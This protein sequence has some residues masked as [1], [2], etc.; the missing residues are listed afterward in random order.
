MGIKFLKIG[1]VY[2]VL[3]IFLGIIMGAT[4]NFEFSSVHAHLSLLG[5]VSMGL[6]G[7]IYHFYPI[8]GETKLAKVHFWLHN[9]G[10]PLLTGG[11]FIVLSSGESLTFLPIIGSNILGA[12]VILFAINLFKHVKAENLKA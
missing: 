7:L 5:W 2:F 6:F 8:A 1:T 4:H 10:T 3:G 9:I 11:I 12:G